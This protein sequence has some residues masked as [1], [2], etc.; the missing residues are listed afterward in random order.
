MPRVNI[1]AQ[2]VP[3]ASQPLLTRN[4]QA[5]GATPNM[6]KAVTNPPAV[7]QGMWAAFGALGA[8]LRSGVRP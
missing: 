8:G 4:H 6:F 7:W 1:Q 3:A 5:F 2:F